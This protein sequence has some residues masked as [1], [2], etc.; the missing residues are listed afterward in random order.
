MEVGGTDILATETL[1]FKLVSINGHWKLPIGYGFINKLTAVTHV[2]LIKS[3]LT[4]SYNSGLIVYSVTYDGACINFSTFKLLC[5][6]AGNCY[7]NFKCLFD[8]PVTVMVSL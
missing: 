6:S 7:V 4:H 3:A 5:F 8:P 2:E 1:V